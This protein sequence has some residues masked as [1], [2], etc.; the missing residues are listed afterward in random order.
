MAEG[1]RTHSQIEIRTVNTRR[2]LLAFIQFPLSLYRSDRFYVPQLTRDMETHFS[3]RNPF[4][5]QAEV[6]FYLALQHGRPAGRIASIINHEH[7]ERHKE[8]AGFFGFYE[9]INDAGVS[10]ALLEA[11]SHD[12]KRHDL[13]TIRGPMSFSTNE[14][15]GFLIEGFESPPMLMTPY[16]PPY[17]GDLMER[18]G[19]VKAKDLYAFIYTVKEELPEKILRVA[20]LAERKG[21]SARIMD[22]R[23]FMSDMRAFREVYNSA[24]ERNWGFLPISDEEITYSGERL[25]PLVVPELIIIA[26][27]DRKPVGFLGL[28]PDYNFVLKKMGGRLDPVTVV[29]ALYYSR[30]IT[31]LRLLLLGIKEEY[32]NRGVDALLFRE[33]FKGVR[34]NGF[35][36]V[37]F[38]W[39]LEDNIPVI[40]HVEL[41]GGDLYKRYRIYE[42]RIREG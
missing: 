2:E 8:K 4:V 25:K 16:N 17:Y 40:R 37:E 18:A 34:K 22:K 20:A 41:I 32:R 36:R 7:I 38:S 30:K 29:K 27:K 26:E 1:L 42:K 33:G 14:E 10:G 39:I 12:L 6:K 23:Q 19:M 31:D 3:S 13:E 35:K 9:S 28:I 15:C 5:R 11:V 24:W 21:I